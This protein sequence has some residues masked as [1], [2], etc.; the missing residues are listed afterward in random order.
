VVCVLWYNADKL[1]DPEFKN[2]YGFLIENLA[3]ENKG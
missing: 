3:L 1:D 2:K